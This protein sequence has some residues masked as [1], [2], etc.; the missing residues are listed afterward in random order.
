MKI[1]HVGGRGSISHPLSR[2][3]D[4]ERRRRALE[5]EVRVWPDEVPAG[6]GARRNSVVEPLLTLRPFAE[7]RND[8]P[9]TILVVGVVGRPR[10]GPI[11]ALGAPIKAPV[12]AFPRWSIEGV[13]DGRPV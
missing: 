9:A 6:R 2:G 1:G 5:E 8:V 10:T 7:P 4:A 12:G 11:P 13:R 3:R